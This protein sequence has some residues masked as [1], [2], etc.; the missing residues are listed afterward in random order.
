MKMQMTSFYANK[1]LHNLKDELEHWEVRER[2][3]STFVVTDSENAIGPDYDFQEISSKMESINKKIVTIKHAI[4]QANAN[5]CIDVDGV[6]MSA[7]SMLIRIAQLKDR[8][9]DLNCMR[10]RASR[11][12]IARYDF[13]GINDGRRHCV[14]EYEYINYDRREVDGAYTALKSELF[15]LETRLSQFN[16]TVRF[17]VDLDV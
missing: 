13:V 14:V 9:R 12:R 10:N 7:D 2:E 3:L 8:C 1:L 4:N 17:E 11:L 6:K 15:K 16:N 5:A